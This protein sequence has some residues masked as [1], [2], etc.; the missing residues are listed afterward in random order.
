MKIITDFKQATE[1]LSDG[2]AL[3]IGTFD[4]IH[5]GHDVLIKK[6]MDVS[7]KKNLK[8]ALITFSP[9]PRLIVA[10]YSAPYLL[11][12]DKEKIKLL[13]NYNL[14]ALIVIKFDE[15]FASKSL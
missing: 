3:T 1:F 15:T 10:P 12:T 6:L 14:D 7:K 2:S 8:S 11:S 4:G 5:V 13:E 9:H